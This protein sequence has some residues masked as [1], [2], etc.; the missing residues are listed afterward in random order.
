[1]GQWVLHDEW[2][3]E[4]DILFMASNPWDMK[5]NPFFFN[6]NEYLTSILCWKIV[7]YLI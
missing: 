5:K 7:I 3:E 2:I 6:I 1:M 4:E